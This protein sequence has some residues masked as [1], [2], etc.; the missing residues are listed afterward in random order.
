MPMAMITVRSAVL[1]AAPVVL[2]PHEVHEGAGDHLLHPEGPGSRRVPAVVGAERLDRGRRAHH[3]AAVGQHAEAR[4][5]RPGQIE[6]HR[7]LVDH[8]DAL[9]YRQR[10]ARRGDGSRV[11]NPLDVDLHRMGIEG[12]AVMEDDAFTQVEGDRVGIRPDLPGSGER[13]LRPRIELLVRVDQLIEDLPPEVGV[14]ARP[15][16]DRVERRGLQGVA[17]PK[18]AAVARTADG[19]R[20]GRQGGGLEPIG[21]ALRRAGNEQAQQ[22]REQKQRRVYARSR[23]RRQ[24]NDRHLG[25]VQLY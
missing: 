24:R 9:D 5:P 12:G 23:P 2:V 8:F 15:A 17:H 19:W 21:A 3:A 20:A 14:G 22:P 10:G 1:V 18:M 7:V 16:Q 25:N 6:T 11:E 4:A 13:R